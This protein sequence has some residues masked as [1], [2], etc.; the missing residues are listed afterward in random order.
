MGRSSSFLVLRYLTGV[1][2]SSAWGVCCHFV[3]I[4]LSG[5]IR[6]QRGSCPF[7]LSF[8][9]PFHYLVYIS[10]GAIHNS[11]RGTIYCMTGVIVVEKLRSRFWHE[12][13][14]LIHVIGQIT[15]SSLQDQRQE[16][17][18]NVLRTSYVLDHLMIAHRTRG[19]QDRPPCSHDHFS[20]SVPSAP[21][22]HS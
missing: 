21:C 8:S 16:S 1:L 4:V 13:N 15:K 19:L 6:L 3:P 2:I 22:L 12:N 17:I 18:K 7:V 5:L 14:L 11:H 20:E 9:P 10:F